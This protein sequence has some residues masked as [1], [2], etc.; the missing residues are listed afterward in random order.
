MK[1][2][3]RMATTLQGIIPGGVSVKDFVAVTGMS[4]ADAGAVLD[5]FAGGGIGTRRDGSYYFEDGDKLRAAIAMLGSGLGIDEIA[6]FLEWRD[7][8]GLAAEILAEKNFAVMRNLM[9]KSPR[10]EIDVVGVRLGIALLV[11]CKHWQRYSTS[12]LSTAV[13]KQIERTKQYVAKT[14]GA[15]AVPAIVTLYQDKVGFIQNVPIVPISQ[16]AS[17]VDEFYGNLDQM[18]TIGRD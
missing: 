7:F 6:D 17:F 15:V 12:A 1:I 5:G 14:P 11:D 4:P 8:E 18:R 2:Y 9:L 3:P 13:K 10:M 16:F